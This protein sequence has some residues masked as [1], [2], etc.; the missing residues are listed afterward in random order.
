MSIKYESPVLLRV[1]AEPSMISSESPFSKS[2]TIE[3]MFLSTAYF[4]INVIMSIGMIMEFMIME[5]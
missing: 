5:F 1:Y 3:A 2:S 4:T